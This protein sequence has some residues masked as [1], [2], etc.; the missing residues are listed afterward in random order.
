MWKRKALKTIKYINPLIGD[1]PLLHDI[2]EP[3]VGKSIR[4][5]P[6][7]QIMLQ[8]YHFDIL[9]NMIRD[10]KKLN[11]NITN[12][13]KI[14]YSF[15]YKALKCGAQIPLKFSK[16]K[17]IPN[18]ESYFLLGCDAPIKYI[19]KICTDLYSDL[20]LGTHSCEIIENM[21]IFY[22]PIK[23]KLDSIY[24]VLPKMTVHLR[25]DFSCVR[26]ARR[27]LYDSINDFELIFD[28][29][30]VARRYDVLN[31]ILKFI[32][33]R[34]SK[35]IYDER[36]HSSKFVYKKFIGRYY[37]RIGINLISEHSDIIMLWI[38]MAYQLPN[39]RKV[40]CDFIGNY[41]LTHKDDIFLNPNLTN[42]QLLQLPETRKLQEL[43]K[44]LFLDMFLNT[45]IEIKLYITVLYELFNVIC[46]E[47]IRNNNS[48]I[49]TFQKI[50]K[51]IVCFI[52][53][54]ISVG[55]N[56]VNCNGYNIPQL[57]ELRDDLILKYKL[58]GLYD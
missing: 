52:E 47:I 1:I 51:D 2:L 25:N 22:S 42:S 18:N 11:S 13:G 34:D 38:L 20:Y 6:R 39:F 41:E 23:N 19:K 27:S 45:S 4:E 53:Y 43:S 46:G 9:I 40:Y 5:I 17:K 48:F 55:S 54:M 3:M 58:A 30:V 37:N 35:S 16:N 28:G 15:I 56:N 7:Y 26:P 32:Y 33:I 10:N 8:S 12:L 44:V 50:D 21:N 57:Y 14:T 29:A 24:T 31:T 36:V 49:T